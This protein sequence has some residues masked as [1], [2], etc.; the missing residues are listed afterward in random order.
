MSH[1]S[2]NLEL[3]GHSLAQVQ[4]VVAEAM[5]VSLVVAY[6]VGLAGIVGPWGYLVPV[7]RRIR[8]QKTQRY[9]HLYLH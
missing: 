6:Q 9:Q 3:V 1:S 2:E 4:P 7:R 5:L 8:G